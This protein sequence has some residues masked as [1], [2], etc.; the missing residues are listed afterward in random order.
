MPTNFKSKI[1]SVTLH[2]ICEL[3]ELYFLFSVSVA[4]KIN[5]LSSDTY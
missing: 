2:I 5:L 3:C 4:L 1:R